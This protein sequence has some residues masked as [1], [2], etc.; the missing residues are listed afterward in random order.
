MTEKIIAVILAGGKSSRFRQSPEQPEHKTFALLKGKPLIQRIVENLT[1]S[2]VEKIV[3]SVDSESTKEEFQ[4]KLEGVLFASN[5]PYSLSFVIDRT[6]IPA[7][8]PLLGLLSAGSQMKNT[9]IFSL[10]CDIVINAEEVEACLFA[11]RKLKVSE[12]VTIRNPDQTINPTLLITTSRLIQRFVSKMPH[13]F[14][15]ARPTD[16]IRFSSQIRMLEFSYEL[17]NINTKDQLRQWNRKMQKEDI[18]THQPRQHFQK[19]CKVLEDVFVAIEGGDLETAIRLLKAESA[20][21]NKKNEILLAK[22]AA[23]DLRLLT[24]IGFT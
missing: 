11:T 5:R 20:C 10:P 18:K 19:S 8:G 24:E 3:I 1:A 15:R 7:K 21:W 13:K 9:T 12:V 16:L 23:M 17:P 2:S 4:E 22:H 14:S 6:D